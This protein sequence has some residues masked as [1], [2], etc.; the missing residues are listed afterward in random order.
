ML[1]F[2]KFLQDFP[3][4]INTLFSMGTAVKLR[5]FKFGAK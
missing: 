5:S 1:I 3:N 2:S 4:Y